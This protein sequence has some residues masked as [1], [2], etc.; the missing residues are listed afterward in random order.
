MNGRGR[1]EGGTDLQLHTPLPVVE[2][3]L[4]LHVFHDRLID[5]L[6]IVPERCVTVWRKRTS[7]ILSD[8][9]ATLVGI[10]RREGDLLGFPLLLL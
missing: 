7:N 3:D 4:Q 9:L 5:V 10:D 1:E 2:P 6:P 8:V